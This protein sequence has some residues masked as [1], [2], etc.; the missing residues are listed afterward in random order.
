VLTVSYFASAEMGC[1]LALGW[2][3]PR[4]VVDLYPEFRIETNGLSV[5]HGRGLLGAMQWYGLDGI[6]A[7]RKDVLRKRILAG[8][9]YSG[10]EQQAILDYCQSDVEALSLLFPRIVPD[11]ANLLP[12]LW[13][14][15]FMKVIAAAE[16]AGV[17]LDAA[18]YR[19]MIEHWPWLRSHAIDQV[20]EII[21][22]FDGEHF[23]TARFETWL[24]EQ[25]MLTDWPTTS[26]GIPA[27]DEQ[28]FR[29]IAA[30]YPQLEP[31]R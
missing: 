23:R 28:T 6:E 4:L 16:R 11:D 25:G 10:E 19:R 26:S 27:L 12:G 8:G 9:P 30:R 2:P 15:E 31:L 29:D 20:N 18:L 5:P 13:R 22:V 24:R 17:P 3:L 14:A 21:P 7:T 1:Y